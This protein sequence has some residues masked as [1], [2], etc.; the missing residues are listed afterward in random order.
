MVEQTPSRIIWSKDEMPQLCAPGGITP[1][2][3]GCVRHG[4]GGGVYAEG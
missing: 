2:G 1:G 3:R 4:A